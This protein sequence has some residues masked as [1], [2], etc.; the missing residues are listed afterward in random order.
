MANLVRI[1]KAIEDRIHNVKER[2]RKLLRKKLTQVLFS[3]ET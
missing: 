3:T 1:L 2:K